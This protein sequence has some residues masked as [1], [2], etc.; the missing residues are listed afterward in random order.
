MFF[1]PGWCCQHKQ[2]WQIFLLLSSVYRCKDHSWIVW[3]P[4]SSGVCL[5]L[6]SSILMTASNHKCFSSTYKPNALFPFTSNCLG[7][8]VYIILWTPLPP[9]YR[10]RGGSWVPQ[11]WHRI[12][13]KKFFWKGRGWTKGGDCLERAN[14]SL[15]Y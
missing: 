5:K 12:E 6:H 3:N 7:C 2:Q 4:F 9:L 10:G 13:M 8:F 1:Q 14:S 15:L 11:I